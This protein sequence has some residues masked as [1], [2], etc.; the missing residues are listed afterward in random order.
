MAIIINYSHSLKLRAVFV[1]TSESCAQIWLLFPLALFPK[2]SF[3][4]ELESH[5]GRVGSNGN[6]TAEWRL[7]CFAFANLDMNNLNL[8][9]LGVCMDHWV[10]SKL[11]PVMINIQ[12]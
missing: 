10:G 6:N 8:Q 9:V 11:K 3:Q 5:G 2:G 1:C 12:G 4:T 7:C